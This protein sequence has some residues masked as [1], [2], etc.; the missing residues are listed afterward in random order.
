MKSEYVTL[1]TVVA[2]IFSGWGGAFIAG[3][4]SRKASTDAID[5]E[6]RIEKDKEKEKNKRELIKLYLYLI[7]LDYGKR[8]VDYNPS[9]Y[10]EINTQKY[11]E[12][13]RD[14]IYKKYHLIHETVI[15]KF[16]TIEEFNQKISHDE[17]YA[18]ANEM[19]I[20]IDVAAST[21]LDMIKEIKKVLDKERLNM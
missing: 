21:Y 4:F 12:Y 5:K 6:R 3:Y 14:A 20:D 1:L 7:K 9:G 19:I 11:N 18:D 13:I 8:V 17:F 15:R 16:N 10:A 2:S